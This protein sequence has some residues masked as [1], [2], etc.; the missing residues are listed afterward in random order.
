MNIIYLATLNL[1][2]LNKVQDL[3]LFTM[4]KCL[5]LPINGFFLHFFLS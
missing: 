1:G 4:N 2:Q 5:Y 3:N